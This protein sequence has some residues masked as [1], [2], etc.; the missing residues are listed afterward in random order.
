MEG[1][2]QALLEMIND[3]VGTRSM[4]NVAYDEAQARHGLQAMI[5]A[6]QLSMTKL[7]ADAWAHSTRKHSQVGA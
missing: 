1:F 6:Y 3:P 2:S 4:A 5:D 7:C